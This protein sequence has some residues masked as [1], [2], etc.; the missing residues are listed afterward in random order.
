MVC[1]QWEAGK[2]GGLRVEPMSKLTGKHF[3]SETVELWLKA[4]RRD[5]FSGKTQSYLQV[6]PQILFI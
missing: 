3:K 2:S 1:G 4:L 5:D 6:S